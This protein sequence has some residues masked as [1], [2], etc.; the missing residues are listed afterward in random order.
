MAQL[1]PIL[2]RQR[3]SWQAVANLL[4][5][6]LMHVDNAT[7]IQALVQSLAADELAELP[8]ANG[9]AELAVTL[10]SAEPA[11]EGAAAQASAQADNSAPGVWPVRVLKPALSA[12]TAEY[13]V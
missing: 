5:P 1:W 9:V 2:V 13:D 7:A 4:A 12:R 10:A 6:K 3:P 8:E 11:Q